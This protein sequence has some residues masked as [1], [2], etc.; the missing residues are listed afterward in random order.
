VDRPRLCVDGFDVGRFGVPSGSKDRCGLHSKMDHAATTRSLR[1]H[2]RSE[3]DGHEIARSAHWHDLHCVERER[4]RAGVWVAVGGAKRHKT[5]VNKER[6]TR[7]ALRWARST[8]PLTLFALLDDVGHFWLDNVRQGCQG[9]SHRST[10]SIKLSSSQ[11]SS[12][13]I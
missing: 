5:S 4:E 1:G 2:S 6:G 9:P 11:A 3:K 7:S 8:T 13:P 10:S 12:S